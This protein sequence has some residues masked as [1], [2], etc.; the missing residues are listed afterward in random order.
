[1]IVV[2]HSPIISL[3]AQDHIATVNVKGAY[4]GYLNHRILF[5]KLG[6]GLVGGTLSSGML[7]AV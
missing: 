1:M 6:S 7:T 5:F 2:Y 4:K 3:P